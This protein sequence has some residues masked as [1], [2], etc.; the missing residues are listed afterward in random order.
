MKFIINVVRILFLALFVF[1]V[2]KGKVMIWLA[3]YGVSLL[4]A[5]VFGR[6]YCGYV[7]PMNTLMIP[8]EWL[9]KKLKLQTDKTPGWLSSG[10]FP[11]L[12][13]VGSIA[14]MLLVQKLL[15]KNIPI[16]LIWL[17]ISVLITIRYK[18]AVFHNLICPFGP[19]QKVFGKFAI[20]SE[21]VNEEVCNGCTLCEKVCPSD[22]IKVKSGNKRAEIATSLCL[23]CTNCQEVCPKKAIRYS[24]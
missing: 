12:A 9:S 6:I 11:W 17:A 18:P 4:A 23:Q 7:C 24:K 15:H 1:L 2:L 22:A 20:F 5:L 3:L 19:L 16:L 14:I 13:L 21:R 8:T 10:K